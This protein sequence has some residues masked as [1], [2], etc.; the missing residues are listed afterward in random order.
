MRYL[1]VLISTA[2]VLFLLVTSPKD[3]LENVFYM[4]LKS[5][6]IQLIVLSAATILVIRSFGRAARTRR[7]ASGLE[8]SAQMVSIEGSRELSAREYIS[9]VQGLAGKPDALI[10]E[11]GMIIPVERKPLAKKLRDRYTAQLLVYLRLVEEFEGCKPTHGYL[12]L[13]PSCRRVRIE[14]SV[15]KQQWLQKLI[16]EMRAIIDGTPPVPAPHPIKC[17]KC[18]VRSRCAARADKNSFEQPG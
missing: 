13:G 2:G 4:S 11:A 12:L 6:G 15:S 16:N 3:P 7:T 17:A 8:S 9:S 18:D 14:N 1:A 5:H 10:D